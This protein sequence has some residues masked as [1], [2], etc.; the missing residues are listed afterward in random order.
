MPALRKLPDFKCK[1]CGK[2]DL[3]V[4]RRNTYCS[5]AC[6]IDL[7]Y[8]TYVDRWKRGLETGYTLDINNGISG[9]IK[10][11]LVEKKGDCCWKCGWAEVHPTTGKVPCQW[12]H[13]DG[14]STNCSEENLERI[15]PNCHSLTPNYGALNKGKSTRQR[16]KV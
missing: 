16:R 1:G 7:A 4:D 14:D 6:R 8:R 10:R 3:T 15:C 5:H 12:N 2:T 13:I 9:Q 11:Y